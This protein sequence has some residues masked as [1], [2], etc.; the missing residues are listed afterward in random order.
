MRS[1]L[2]ILAISLFVLALGGAGRAPAQPNTRIWDVPLG[3][4]LAELP[5]DEW[6]DPACG[7]NG[8]PPTL[9][10]DSFADYS[11]CPVEAETGLREVW[12]VYDDELEFIARAQRDPAVIW[13]FMANRFDTQQIIT[14]LLVDNSGRMQ[15]YRVITDPRTPAE[16]RL[17]AYT[18][19]PQFRGIVGSASWTCIDLPAG[20]RETPVQ[21]VFVKEDCEK[22]TDEIFARVEGRRMYKPGQDIRAGIGV[23]RL[24]PQ[25]E[26]QF[27]SSARLEVYSREAVRGA[28]CC[29]GAA[30]VGNAG[31]RRGRRAVGVPQY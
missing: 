7:T 5:Q 19:A 29:P 31:V 24:I 26:G 23:R 25:R 16:L 3:T 10:L 14:S 12:F 13:R 28:P 2:T 11:Q 1:V 22:V 15:G 6:V 17:E 21:G 18:L 27:E 4:P 30:S 8:G 9:L 20:E